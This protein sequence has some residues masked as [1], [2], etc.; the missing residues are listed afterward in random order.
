MGKYSGSSTQRESSIH[1]PKEPHGIWQ[2]IG[3]LMMLIVPTL[4]IAIGI[5]AVDYALI[6]KLPIPSQL[7]GYPQLPDLIRKSTGLMIILGQ[8]TKV[9]NFY[10]YAVASIAALLILGSVIS[11]V[12][13]WAYRAVS[14]TRYGPMDAPPPKRRITKKSR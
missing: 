3:C 14:P 8:M 7:L 1:K 4:S 11:L 9:K 12:Y 6:E 2:G 5:Q 13:A 10:A